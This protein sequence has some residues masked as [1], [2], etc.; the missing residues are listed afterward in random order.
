MNNVMLMNGTQVNKTLPTGQ[1]TIVQNLNETQSDCNRLFHSFHLLLQLCKVN[2][3]AVQQGVY[4]YNDDGPWK[5][6]LEFSKWFVCHFV[7]EA[8]L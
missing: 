7:C 2:F 3:V 6:V 8:K 1:L 5:A 4:G